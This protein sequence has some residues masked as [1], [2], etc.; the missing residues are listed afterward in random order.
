MRLA[1]MNVGP[2]DNRNQDSG[3]P[4]GGIYI[5]NYIYMGNFNDLASLLN[6]MV[7]VTMQKL[8]LRKT[9]VV[10]NTNLPRYI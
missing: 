7:R 10:N 3:T 8:V 6:Y 9:Q 4:T 1:A 5:Y 2:I